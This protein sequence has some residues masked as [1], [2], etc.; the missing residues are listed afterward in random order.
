MVGADTIGILRNGRLIAEDKPKNL[1]MRFSANSL[2][3]LYSKL[4]QIDDDLSQTNVNLKSDEYEGKTSL[5]M[6]EWPLC[7]PRLSAIDNQLI[8]FNFLR[9]FASIKKN[10][11]VM[12]GNPI[13]MLFFFVFPSIQMIF[14]SLSIGQQVRHIPIAIFNGDKFGPLSHKLFKSLD[15]NLMKQE[16]YSTL[17]SA[18][19]AVIKGNVWT[20]VAVSENFSKLIDLRYNR[21][22]NITVNIVFILFDINFNINIV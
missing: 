15:N 6:A 22:Q 19:D 17:D 8:N 1:L 12:R 14:F 21:D 2:N 5:P 18:I 4:C 9:F 11:F 3:D 7:G 16:K 10:L 20:A 13:L